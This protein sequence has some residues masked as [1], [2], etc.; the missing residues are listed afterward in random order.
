MKML[1]SW[2]F[3][4]FLLCSTTSGDTAVRLCGQVLNQVLTVVCDGKI[5]P[6]PLKRSGKLQIDLY[7]AQ[8]IIS[9][10]KILT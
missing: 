10:F 1:V 6:L 7:C 3:L 5:N 8:I 9:P 2:L 4:T